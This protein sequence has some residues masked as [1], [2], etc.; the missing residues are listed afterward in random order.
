M[1]STLNQRAFDHAKQLIEEG[2]FVPDDR[3]LWSEHQPSAEQ[4]NRFIEDH[5]FAEYGKWYPGVD[6]DEDETT[7]VHYTFPY[8]DFARVHRRGVLSAEVRAGQY[9]DLRH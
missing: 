7:K 5:G 1:A 6:H 8:G 3:D 2:Q 9:H 4:E